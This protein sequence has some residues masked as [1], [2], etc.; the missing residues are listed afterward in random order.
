MFFYLPDLLPYC[1]AVMSL[2]LCHKMLSIPLVGCA[3]LGGCRGDTP[4]ETAPSTASSR[5]PH[6]TEVG[7]RIVPGSE[8]AGEVAAQVRDETE[9]ARQAGR[10][11]VVYVGASWCEPCR[12]FHEAAQSKLLDSAFPE[13]TF[14][15]FDFDRDE[16]RLRAA[17]Y[18]SNL[19]PLFALPRADG[20]ASRAIV[21]G[22]IKGDGAVANLTPR[23]RNLLEKRQP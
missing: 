20:H 5:L 3:L 21:Q 6:P 1:D 17:G 13:V 2:F 4:R 16:P 14:L 23:L 12:R 9:R 11:L 22:S 19:L 8:R 7:V 18:V 15:E 10:M